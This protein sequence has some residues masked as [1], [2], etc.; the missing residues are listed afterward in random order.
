MAKLSVHGKAHLAPLAPGPFTWFV[1]GSSL[2]RSAFAAWAGE[3]GYGVPDFGGSF[4]ARLPDHRLAFDVHSRFWGGATANP[5]PA[6]GRAVE[7]L[8]VPLPAE[9]RSLVDHKEGALSGLYEPFEVEVLP[10]SGGPAVKAIAYRAV[11][12]RRLPAEEPPSGAFLEAVI[13][14]ALWAGL[15]T[16]WISELQELLDLQGGQPARR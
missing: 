6:A 14:G 4:A 13:R 16:E 9:S 1:Y 8:A 10:L 5:V 3:H 12:E 2:D 7:G 15:S 11:A